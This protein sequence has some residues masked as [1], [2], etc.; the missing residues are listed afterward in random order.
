MRNKNN[1]CELPGVVTD[2]R[3]TTLETKV[4]ELTSKIGWL[5]YRVD[6]IYK[7]KNKK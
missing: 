6:K 1:N 7:N 3:L 4:E 2:K 5:L